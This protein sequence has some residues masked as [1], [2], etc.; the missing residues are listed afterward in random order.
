MYLVKIYRKYTKGRRTTARAVYY[1]AKIAVRLFKKYLDSYGEIKRKIT[2]EGSS[3]TPFVVESPSNDL[4]YE[5]I[6]EIMDWLDEKK[7][8][9]WL[10]GKKKEE[11]IVLGY[12]HQQMVFHATALSFNS[13]IVRSCFS[14]KRKLALLESCKESAEEAICYAELTMK[15]LESHIRELRD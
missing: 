12:Y 6:I 14:Q 10:D 11:E 4:R 5:Q 1:H 2:D 9:E 7:E 15:I 3:F 13:E 8:W